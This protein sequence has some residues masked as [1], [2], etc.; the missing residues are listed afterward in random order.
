MK[1]ASN[2]RQI[3][4]AL[5]LYANDNKGAYPPKLEVLLTTEDITPEVF[6]CPDASDTPAPGA[7]PQQQAAAVSKGGHDSYVYVGANLTNS[8]SASTVVAY[9]PLTDHANAGSN[10]LWG[11]GHVSF[12][13]SDQ[14]KK[15]IDQVSAGQ[16]PPTLPH[17]RTRGSQF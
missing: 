12:E 1:C 16:N 13:R 5:L 2:L 17:V 3:G 10:I 4:Q 14:A 15:I 11:D 8:A 9:E 7:T 6:I